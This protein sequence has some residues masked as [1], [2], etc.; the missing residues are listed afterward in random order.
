M[1]LDDPI[2][3]RDAAALTGK[4]LAT[5]RRWRREG[6]LKRHDRDATGR[7]CLSRAEVLMV[8]GAQASDHPAAPVRRTKP[9]GGTTTENA[10]LLERLAGLERLA[11]RERET[12]DF[13]RERLVEATERA[14]RAE[15]QADRLAERLEA[16]EGTDGKVRGLLTERA[17]VLDMLTEQEREMVEMRRRMAELEAERGA[18]VLGRL[19]A[20]RRR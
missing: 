2:P 14:K 6:R 8:C 19:F 7:V 20:G 11:A 15:D 4:S 18:G 16:L 13:L 3:L 10:H 1:Q 9:S 5:L 17:T 12:A